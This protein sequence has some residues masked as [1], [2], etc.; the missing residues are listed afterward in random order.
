MES[1]KTENV[2]DALVIESFV[3]STSDR[4]HVGL[5]IR[6]FFVLVDRMVGWVVEWMDGYVVR[7]VVG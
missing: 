6:I 7:V 5:V 4:L 2:C 3:D 1:V